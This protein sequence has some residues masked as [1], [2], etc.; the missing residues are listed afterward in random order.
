LTFVYK[1]LNLQAHTLTR[2]RLSAGNSP[3]QECERVPEE[4][5]K[6]E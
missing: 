2:D 6:V 3:G 5:L 4:K 1:N